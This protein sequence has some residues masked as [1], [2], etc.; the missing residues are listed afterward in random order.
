MHW[1]LKPQR[2]V[3]ETYTSFVYK[4][5]IQRFIFYNPEASSFFNSFSVTLILPT[6]FERF[7]INVPNFNVN[8]SYICQFMIKT[9]IA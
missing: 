7:K 1:E 5:R 4:K 8:F 9:K 6:S 3:R 2:E